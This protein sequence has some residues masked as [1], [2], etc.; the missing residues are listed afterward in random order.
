MS[1]TTLIEASPRDTQYDAD[2]LLAGLPPLLTRV[3]VAGPPV[4]VFVGFGGVLLLLLVPPLA[5]VVTLMGVTLLALLALAAL[6]ALTGAIVAAPFLVVHRVR[7]HGLPHVS[8]PL[9]RLHHVK[10]RRV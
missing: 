6:V 10:V 1:T 2:E 4:W 7:A 8:L 3:P 9:P 5:L